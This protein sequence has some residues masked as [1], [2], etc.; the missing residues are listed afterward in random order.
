MSDQVPPKE[1]RADPQFLRAFAECLRNPPK[2]GLSKSYARNYCAEEMEL[3]ANNLESQA[4]RIAELQQLHDWAEPQLHCCPHCGSDKLTQ[5]PNAVQSSFFQEL[6]CMLENGKECESLW[7]ARGVII[8]ALELIHRTQ[9]DKALRPAAAQK[10]ERITGDQP[11]T[12]ARCQQAT[13]PAEPDMAMLPNGYHPG[14]GCSCREC[15]RTY[16]TKSA[17]PR[18]ST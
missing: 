7:T 6:S 5:P 15:L 10:Y 11:C 16:P 18:T 1:H 3:A 12:C 9:Q 4:V 13:T 17:N 8:D 14:V 2:S